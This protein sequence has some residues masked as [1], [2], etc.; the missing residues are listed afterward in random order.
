MH[1]A[2]MTS[3]AA[4][5]GSPRV[6]ATTPNAIAPR[7]TTAAQINLLRIDMILP[8]LPVLSPKVFPYWR[9]LVDNVKKKISAACAT[10]TQVNQPGRSAAWCDATKPPWRRVGAWRSPVPDS[11]Q[12]TAQQRER[13]LAAPGRTR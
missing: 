3:H 9:R 13:T 10:L 12:A 7:T 6:K 4:L 11:A 2:A 8:R 5:I 1:T